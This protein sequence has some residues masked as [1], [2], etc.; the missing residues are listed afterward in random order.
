[1][2]YRSQYP[3][4]FKIYANTP[5]FVPKPG[6]IAVYTGGVYGHTNVVVGPSTTTYFTA[7]DQN[8]NPVSEAYGSRALLVKHSYSDGPGGVRYFVRPPYKAEPKPKPK[9]KPSTPPKDTSTA[10][11]KPT[12]KPTETEEAKEVK[13]VL[14]DVK[15][16]KF[17]VDDIDTNYPAFIPHRIAKGKDR[18]RSPKKVLIRDA[19]TM[20]S[21]LDLYTTRRKYIRTSEL[22]HYYIDRNYIWQPRYEQIEVPSAPDCLVIEV[23][24][25]YSDSKNDFI[26]NE[27]HAMNY[28]IGRMKF[29]SI[30]M[31]QSSFIIE[32]EYWRTILEHGAWNTV[33]KGKPSKRVK[34]KTIEALIN[35]YQ[36]REKL[37]NDIPSDK[38]TK[39]KVKVE[40]PKDDE[41]TSS[42]DNK[43]STNTSKTK[44]KTTTSAKKK[45]PTVTVVYSRYT[46]N[47]A[48]NIQMA[49]APQVNYGSGWYNASR[50]ATSAAM[51]NAT[52]WNNSKMRY[53]MLNLGK[54]QGIP[55]SKL[56]QILK[57]KGSL[58][59]QGQ[60]FSDGCKKYNINE[61][62]LIAHAFLESG[63]GTSNFA[64]GRYGIYNYFGINAVDWAPNKAIDYA[65][66]EGWT[67]PY[68]GIVG[69]AKFVRKGYIDNGQQTLYRMRWNPQSP[70]NHQYATDI[71]W[72]K[73]QANT[74]YNLYSQ[75]GMKGEY[76]I[77]DRY[78]S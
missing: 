18:G 33:A 53:Q 9:P 31:K 24:G 42:S 59:G 39:R 68:K 27:I 46:Y 57:G 77:R 2:A 7:V 70:G 47:N 34:D 71:N 32:S 72:C 37:L 55:V 8:W 38:I 58:S 74:I 5:N 19:G 60:A 48:L 28:L 29:H 54:Y 75:I 17:T 22:P 36:N 41:T 12:P 56:N 45:Q 6:D 10:P 63:Y 76:F 51:N 11:S 35:L 20:C 67:T 26:L 43:T 52:I 14:K 50:S 3:A 1:M 4:G 44:P 16:I 66:A 21:V 69:G 62:Y 15:E 64:S 78:K 25:D 40:V 23:C 13:T 73:H 49:K 30:P 61:I 65:R